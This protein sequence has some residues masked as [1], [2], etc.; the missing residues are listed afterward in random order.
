MNIYD[1]KLPTERIKIL[2]NEI[3][4]L[5]SFRES[6]PPELHNGVNGF[7]E[8]RYKRI[9][10]IKCAIT[11]QDLKQ[12]IFYANYDLFIPELIEKICIK[13]KLPDPR[14]GIAWA[15]HSA[16]EILKEIIRAIF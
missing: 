5:K 7:I 10:Q 13:Q 3:K 8:L 12:A 9:K 1:F 4:S 2:E 11:T 14:K 16:E 6:C 15:T